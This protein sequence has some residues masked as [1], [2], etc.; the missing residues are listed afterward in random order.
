MRRKAPEA[1]LQ[2]LNKNLLDLAEPLQKLERHE[3]DDGLSAAANLDLT[4]S[5]DVQAL[6]I[7]LDRGVVKL[8]MGKTVLQS[9]VRTEVPH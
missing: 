1:L 3:D 4:G 2:L 8:S 7:L 5:T 6:Q 9:C